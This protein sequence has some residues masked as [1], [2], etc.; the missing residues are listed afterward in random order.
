MINK[1]QQEA[2]QWLDR[3]E[4]LA[5]QNNI[6]LRLLDSVRDC[7]KALESELTEAEW[8]Q[9]CLEIGELLDR[10]GKQLNPQRE[11]SELESDIAQR[12][13]EFLERCR[14]ANEMA[15]N[16]YCG[17]STFYI[18]AAENS[19]QEMT[20]VKANFGEVTN[21][22]RLQGVFRQIGQK[23][24]QQIDEQQERYA[25]AVDQNYQD[26]FDRM[27]GLLSATGYD[28]GAKSKFYNAYYAN[29]DTMTGAAQEYVRNCEKGE[30]S[31]VKLAEE[32]RP[33]LWEL[34]SRLKKKRRFLKWIPA[35]ILIICLGVNLVQNQVESAQK[36]AETSAQAAEIAQKLSEGGKMTADDAFAVGSALLSM[37][38]DSS[39]VGAEVVGAFILEVGLPLL[40]LAILLY[41]LW[42]KAVNRRYRAWVIKQAGALLSASVG[43][44]CSENTLQLAVQE[45]YRQTS[46]YLRNQYEGL[47]TELIPNLLPEEEK[48][49]GNKV[50]FAT[51]CTEWENIRRKAV[52]N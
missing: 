34:L 3:L 12:V 31:I 23:Y 17:G 40:L 28:R 46:G 14:N 49:D 43:R 10:I 27:K 26:A 44:F 33:P 20:N 19:M 47:L 5:M 51:L 50:I 38:G 29:Q 11:Q 16:E 7:K 6:K 18:Q 35:I 39:S 2:C 45:S 24:K 41:F 9:T 4:E 42:C 22:E 21:Q 13:S 32:L 48:E 30:S 25:K 8:R 36:A 1:R 52:E 37:K 15:Q